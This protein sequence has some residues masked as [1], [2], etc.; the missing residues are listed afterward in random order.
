MGQPIDDIIADITRAGAYRR[1]GHGEHIVWEGKQWLVTTAMVQGFERNGP[2]WSPSLTIHT[3]DLRDG[4]EKVYTP[5]DCWLFKV[6]G[7][8]WA[9]YGEFERA[10]LNACI[11]HGIKSRHIATAIEEARERHERQAAY[12]LRRI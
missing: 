9:N 7:M 12:P 11:F 1:M 10:F 8:E 5:A 3:D 4:L 6:A 2:S